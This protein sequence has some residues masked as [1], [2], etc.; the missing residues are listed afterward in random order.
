M[1]QTVI[2]AAATTANTSSTQT[3]AAGVS[4]TFAIYA[5]SGAI[6]AGQ[7]A[8]LYYDTPGGNV[9]IPGGALSINNPI[10]Q[11]AGP[12]QVI[13]VKDPATASFGVLI[14]T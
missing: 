14:E 13:C 4:A 8:V 10:V 6:D 5:A 3:I 1:A 12:A 11:V 9:P 7:R 2:N